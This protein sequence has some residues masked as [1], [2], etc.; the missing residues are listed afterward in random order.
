[1]KMKTLRFENIFDKCAVILFYL[2]GKERDPG[3]DLQNLIF[4][5]VVDLLQVFLLITGT[6]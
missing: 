3:F 4:N 2:Q 6:F 5:I 1:M